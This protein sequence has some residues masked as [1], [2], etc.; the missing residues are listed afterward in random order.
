[1]IALVALKVNSLFCIVMRCAMLCYAVLC[2]AVLCCAV[3]CCAVPPCRAMLCC[4]V[5]GLENIEL[6]SFPSLP[7]LL[8]GAE[9][10]DVRAAGARDVHDGDAN[11]HGGCRGG[12][13]GLN[14]S[15]VDCR[16]T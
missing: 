11:G 16:Y 2:C 14:V 13:G 15:P 10:V 12:E 8:R 7:S 4:V 1:M 5:C 6:N 9:G 3:L